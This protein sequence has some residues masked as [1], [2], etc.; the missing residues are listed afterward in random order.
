MEKTNHIWKNL[1]KEITKHFHYF[2]RKNKTFDGETIYNPPSKNKYSK[3]K[4][5][6]IKNNLKFLTGSRNHCERLSI[7]YVAIQDGLIRKV[8]ESEKFGCR[9]S[10]CGSE[11]YKYTK[12]DGYYILFE[13]DIKK[14]WGLELTDNANYNRLA[15]EKYLQGYFMKHFKSINYNENYG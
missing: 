4:I 5:G 1:P 2:D 15:L 14:I 12:D 7:V 9:I 3:A 13:K 6:H 11:S 8:G 10:H